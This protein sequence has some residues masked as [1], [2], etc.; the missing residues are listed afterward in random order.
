MRSQ[1]GLNGVREEWGA[2]IRIESVG[3]EKMSP[4][5]SVMMGIVGANDRIMV[6][7]G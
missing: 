5:V 1:R 4:T 3:A 7:V 6:E 2:R